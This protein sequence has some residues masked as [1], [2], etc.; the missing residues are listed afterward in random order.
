M[1]NKAINIAFYLCVFIGLFAFFYI[2]HPMIIFDADDWTYASY[3]RRP[4]PIPG[5]YNGI[6]VLPETFMSFASEIGAFLVYPVLKDYLMSLAF[7]YA[8]FL[9]GAILVYLILIEK[10]VSR[11]SKE[12]W[13]SKAVALSF[14]F[15]HFLIFKNDWSSNE[16]LF[17]AQDPTCVFNYIMPA[18]LNASLTIFLLEKEWD[19]ISISSD[20]R[21]KRMS[22]FSASLLILAMY[23]AVFSSMFHNIIFATFCGVKLIAFRP[24]KLNNTELKK[25]F[26]NSW[27]YVTGLC[28]WF[29]ALIIQT[30]DG[31]NE[32]VREQEK[33]AGLAESISGFAGKMSSVNK[34]AALI[35]VII[36]AAAIFRAVREKLKL[37]DMKAMPFIVSSGILTT[38][39][40]VLM[41][42]VAGKGY[43]RRADVLISIF[44]WAFLAAALLLAYVM[45]ESRASL[46]LLVL[47]FVLGA[48]SLNYCK[49]YADYNV[50]GLSWEQTYAASSDIVAQ[51]QAADEAGASELELHVTDNEA[52]G[53]IWPYTEYLGDAV[54]DTLFRHGIIKKQIKTAVIFDKAKNAELCITY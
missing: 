54:S 24:K 42:A 29:A 26:A 50:F 33:T 51:F 17:Y 13:S 49:S 16:H 38:V 5:G 10:I 46:L 1:K 3:W 25:F 31:R 6:K 36:F 28:M 53:N 14:L 48:Q 19:G 2:A 23:L 8:A 12:S 32:A 4:L 34:M 39:Y 45:N 11:I 20:I 18:I 35:F 7:T 30:L 47:T 52:W 40:L 21:Q 27:I 41:A 22:P 9:S 37:K 43:I 44:F 15:L